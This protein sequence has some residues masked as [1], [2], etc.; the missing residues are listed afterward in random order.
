MS[1]RKIAEGVYQIDYYPQGRKGKR[2]QARYYG[3]ERSARQ[4]EREVRQQR[5]VVNPTNP[6]IAALIPPYLQW[7]VLFRA[8]ATCRDIHNSMHTL[9]PHFGPHQCSRLAPT[10]FRDYQR[11]RLASGVTPRTV[12]KEI[13]YLRGLLRWAAKEGYAQP[14]GFKVERLKERRPLPQIPTPQEVA[15]FIAQIRQDRET[16]EILIRLFYD[17]G[18]RWTEATTLRG[19]HLHWPSGTIRV[20]G[21]GGRERIVH[22]TP[23]LK[24][25]LKSRRAVEPEGYLCPNP[26]T[27]RP[28][29]SF[30]STLFRLVA[31]RTG[32]RRLHAHIFRHAWATDTLAAGADIRT[33]QANLGHR[34]ITTTQWYTQVDNSHVRTATQ[35]TAAWR[36]RRVTTRVKSTATKPASRAAKPSGR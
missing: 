31:E 10:I 11:L 14:L 27:G 20:V 4:Y 32:A 7:I 6:T 5:P 9:E 29:T 23:R 8:P 19:H 25:L 30:F 13:D 26:R 35:H 16:K 33:I 17:C 12:N 1:V 21:K 22:L 18:L 24:A 34:Q 3:T 28:Y 15:V 2:V 36:A